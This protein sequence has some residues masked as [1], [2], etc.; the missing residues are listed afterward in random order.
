MPFAIGPKI[1][2]IIPKDLKTLIEDFFS[3]TDW[4]GLYLTGGT[5]LA[6]YYFGHRLSEDADL[7]THDENLFQEAQKALKDPKTFPRG[8]ISQL[9]TTSYIVQFHY[10]SHETGTSTKVE[11]VLD[12][13]QHITPPLLV[14]H[15][16]IDSLEDILSNKITCLVSRNAVKDY[17]DLY[18]LIPASHLTAKEL[19]VLGQIKDGGVDPLILGRQIECIF[20]APQPPPDLLI[21]TDWE[22]LKLFF[23]KFQ[24]ECFELIRP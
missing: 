13:P 11:V 8:T 1:H 17:L 15:V 12:T 7:F 3:V 10:H 18:H 20:Q 16:W 24:K 14:G 4:K 2:N 6:E 22:D 9:R 19:V 5:C 23:K 21:R